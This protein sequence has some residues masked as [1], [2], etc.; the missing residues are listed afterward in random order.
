MAKLTVYGTPV[1]TYVRT[2]RLLLEGAGTDY[3]LKSVDIFNGESQSAEYLAKNPF[4]KAPT[5]E[6]D[7]ALV[8]NQIS[9]GSVKEGVDLDS[10]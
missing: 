4:G 3:D 6:L 7:G 5:L 9:V 8:V 1:S 10:T 2:V